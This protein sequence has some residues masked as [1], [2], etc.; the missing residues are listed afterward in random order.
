MASIEKIKNKKGE[1]TSY[2]IVVSS[3]FD[4]NGRRVK[5]KL[6]WTPEPGMTVKQTEKALKR[7]AADFE[8]SIEQ[9]YQLDTRQTFSDYAA[10]FLALKE[11]NGGAASTVAVDK[12]LLTRILPEIGHLKLTDIRPQHLNNFY[13]KLRQ[14]GQRVGGEKATAI[15]DLDTQLADH[16]ISKAQLAEIAKISA[17]TVTSACRGQTISAEKAKAISN[18]L[19]DQQRRYFQSSAI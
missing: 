18:A 8:R 16:H 1:I 7:A 15:V 14:P 4:C 12:Y 19:G 6:P 3:G 10:Y 13:R 9:G 11:D 2:R 5:H 17:S